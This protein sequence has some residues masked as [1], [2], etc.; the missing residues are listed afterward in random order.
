[1]FDPSRCDLCGDCLVKC[2]YVNYDRKKARQ[3]VAALIAGENADI[4]TQCVTCIACNEFCPT[5]ANPFDR[6]SELQEK[7]QALNIPQSLIDSDYDAYYMPNIIEKGKPDKAAMSLCTMS[8]EAKEFSP[9]EPKTLRLYDSFWKG[10]SE[11][12]IFEGQMFDGMTMVRG[13]SYFCVTGM[14]HIGIDIGN[15]GRLAP[16]IR[17]LVRSL[18]ALGKDKVIIAHDDGYAMLKV[19][20]PEFGIELPFKPVHILEYLRDYLK[21]H[22]TSITKL[23][24]KVAYQRPCSSRY[25]PEN[26][27][28]LNEIFDLIGVERVNRRY[29]RKDALCCGAE[30]SIAQAERLKPYQEKNVADALEHGAE[31]MVFLCPMCYAILGPKAQQKDMAAIFVSDLCRMGLGEKHFPS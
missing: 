11:K 10:G 31:A 24:R 2:P 25:L 29:D 26:D 5:Q 28:L 7:K 18:S 13:G 19:K 6:I 12:T 14:V 8:W 9:E 3:E 17:K 23:N 20:V 4:L 27:L 1:M 22:Q 30:C 16:H 21:E 15:T